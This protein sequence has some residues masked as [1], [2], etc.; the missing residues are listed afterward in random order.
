M[1]RWRHIYQQLRTHNIMLEPHVWPTLCVAIDNARL[2]FAVSQTDCTG[3]HKTKNRQRRTEHRKAHH[4]SG[5]KRLGNHP[6]YCCA[7]TLHWEIL[8][9]RGT[10]ILCP[11]KGLLVS[12]GTA[13]ESAPEHQDSRSRCVESNPEWRQRHSEPSTSTM[14]QSHT[15]GVEPIFVVRITQDEHIHNFKLH[16]FWIGM[17]AIV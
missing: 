9:R 16:F 17:Y 2:N 11:S 12:F 10:K 5:C 3:F 1:S 7:D 15:C 14:I 4:C 13:L 8:S 6:H